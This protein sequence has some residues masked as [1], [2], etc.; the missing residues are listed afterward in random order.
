MASSSPLDVPWYKARIAAWSHLSRLSTRELMNLYLAIFFLFAIF[1]FYDDL[2]N[3]NAR[4]QVWIVLVV[5][6]V[7]GAYAVLYPFCLIH[8]SRGALVAVA[9]SNTFTG[10]ALPTWIRN[11]SHHI[12]PG[13][14]ISSIDFD[15][16]GIL[17]CPDRVLHLFRLIYSRAGLNRTTH[18]NELDLAHG[19]Q[20][21]LVP[22]I[23]TSLN[24]Y[25]LHGISIPSEKVGGDLVDVVSVSDGGTVAYVADVSGHGLQAGILMGMIKTAVRTILLEDFD[26]PRR[27]LHALCDRLNRALPGVKEAHMYATLSALYPRR[28]AARSSTRW[29]RIPPSSIT[30]PRRGRCQN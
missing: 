11:S 4:A 13:S 24:G 1:G 23:T 28:P 9:L 30:R 26:D 29:P 12:A 15:A 19:I 10:V 17:F 14:L 2:T 8:R 6:L 22:P 18:S 5:A 25:D 20:R 7:S 16:N 3:T 21:T 27:L